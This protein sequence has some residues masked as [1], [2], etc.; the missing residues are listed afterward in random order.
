[1][2]HLCVILHHFHNRFYHEYVTSL[3]EKHQYVQNTSNTCPAKVGEIV[4]IKQDVIRRIRWKKGKIEQ[5]INGADGFV[6]GAVFRVYQEK[7]VK[8]APIKSPLQHLIPLEIH[9]VEDT[10]LKENIE[11]DLGDTISNDTQDLSAGGNRTTITNMIRIA[12]LNF[13]ILR[14]LTVRTTNK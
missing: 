5:L 6:R 10:K 3:R 12:N 8:T 11:T 4:L 13:R 7:S 14:K 1:M 2:N 9:D